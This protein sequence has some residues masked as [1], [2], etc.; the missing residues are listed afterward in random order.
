MRLREWLNAKGYEFL[1]ETDTEVIPNLVD[2]YYEWK[3]LFEAVVKATSK[4]EGSYAIGVIA[5]MNQ[6]RLLQ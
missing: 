4:L 2:Y 5:T 1:S 3:N 6:I